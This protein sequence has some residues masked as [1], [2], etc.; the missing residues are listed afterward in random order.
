MSTSRVTNNNCRP[1]S[2]KI[3]TL[4]QSAPQVLSNLTTALPAVVKRIKGEWENVQSLSIKT[5]SS[6]SLPIWSCELGGEKG[7]RWDGL[8]ATDG[9]DV[10]DSE[11][12]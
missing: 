12:Q 5:N 6:A 4:S 10:S 8:V 9:H 11:A 3:G 2:I 7:G 1:R